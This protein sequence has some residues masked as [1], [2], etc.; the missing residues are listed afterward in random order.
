MLAEKARF[1]LFTSIDLLK[2][3]NW[4]HSSATVAEE[5][6]EKLGQKTVTNE[7]HTLQDIMN[8]EGHHIL[9]R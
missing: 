9:L 8:N 6:Y 7:Q 2:W 5:V 4:V 1:T 3:E